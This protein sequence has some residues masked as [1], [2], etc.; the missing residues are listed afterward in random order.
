MKVPL[1]A[2]RRFLEL[3]RARTA[4]AKE[5]LDFVRKSLWIGERWLLGLERVWDVDGWLPNRVPS[6]LVGV[7]EPRGW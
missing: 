2:T 7:W 5:L 3:I 4:E 6:R 1:L